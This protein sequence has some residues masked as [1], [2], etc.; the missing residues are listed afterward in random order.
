MSFQPHPIAPRIKRRPQTAPLPDMVVETYQLT[1]RFN[2]SLAIEEVSLHV[3]RG[4]ICGFIGPSGCGKTTTV[5][6]LTGIYEPT[7]GD[8]NVLGYDPKHFTQS[9]RARI[10]YMPQHF[11]LYPDLSVQENLNFAASIYGVGIF[12]RTRRIRQ[13]LEFVELEEHRN[14]LARNISGGMQRRLSLAATMVHDPEL[15]FLDEPTAGIDPV[16]RR[17]LWDHF[18]EMQRQGC[19]LFITTQY[20]GEAAYC[21]YVGVMANGWLLFV[22]TPHGL[23]HRAFGGDIVDLTTDRRLSTALLQKLRQLPLVRRDFHFTGPSSLRLTVDDAATAIPEIMAFCQAQS[24][25]VES[26]QE[27]TPP[28]DDVFVEL[29]KEVPVRE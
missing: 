3:P 21:D 27:Y 2:G 24:V 16:L 13:L 7:Y 15:L 19:T 6:L 8:I 11:V 1:K 25:E 18:Q 29:V 5:R 4:T 20:V 10:G 14:K 26:I 28:F 23:R 22:D 12:Q 9:V 17:R